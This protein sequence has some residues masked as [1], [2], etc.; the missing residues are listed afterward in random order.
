MFQKYVS[1]NMVYSVSILSILLGS[2]G[3]YVIVES[4]WHFGNHPMEGKLGSTLGLWDPSSLQRHLQQRSMLGFGG[5]MLNQ[6]ARGGEEQMLNPVVRQKES[7]NGASHV[8]GLGASIQV[9][10]EAVKFSVFK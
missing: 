10:D 4:R 9:L 7:R 5:V 3:K 2:K 8:Y 1:F 6:S